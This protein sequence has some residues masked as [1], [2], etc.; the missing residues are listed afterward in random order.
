MASCV[1]AIDVGGTFTDIA[2]ADL[3]TGQLW[4]T[5][6]PTTPYDQSQGFATGV[7]KILQQADKTP[8]DVV[9]T[10]HG[11]TVATN[12][13]IERKGSPLALLTTAGCRYVL[14]IGRH[15]VP[16]SA[17][18]YLWVKPP[19]LVTPEHIYE[20]PERL[21]H[22][23]AVQAPLDE[24]ACIALLR[25]LQEQ[26]FPVIAISLLH[27]YANPLHEQR[28][29]ALCEQYLSDT[30]LSVSSEVLPQF[31]EY[32]R[33]MATVLNALQSPATREQLLWPSG[34]PYARYARIPPRR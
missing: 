29:K 21:A 9:A 17:H 10:L 31:R 6:T 34:P 8:G 23:G 15:D 2:L 20:I 11:S 3:D 24:A 30:P 7:A 4:T 16:K 19:R 5:K 1:I 22:T 12:M 26:R 25:R 33:T 13:I 27:A 18:M 28:L 14:H 32:E